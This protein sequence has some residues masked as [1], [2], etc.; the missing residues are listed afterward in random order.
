MTTLRHQE[1]NGTPHS[2]Y[3]VL[4][5]CSIYISCFVGYDIGIN[6]LNRYSSLKTNISFD[7]IQ[8]WYTDMLNDV[9][10]R[11]SNEHFK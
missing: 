3:V 1:N 6:F 7:Y 2:K 11:P 8:G 5:F 4:F 10:A 9:F